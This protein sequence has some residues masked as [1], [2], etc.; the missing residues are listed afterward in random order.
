MRKLTMLLLPLLLLALSVAAR[1]GRLLADE[2]TYDLVP[3]DQAAAPGA[4]AVAADDCR[5]VTELRLIPTT[6]AGWHALLDQMVRGLCDL[7]VLPD[8]RLYRL[9][10]VA[11]GP[12]PAFSGTGAGG[13][14]LAIRFEPSG[15]A[16]VTEKRAGGETLH[17][18]AAGRLPPLVAVGAH[19][20]RPESADTAAAALCLE[21]DTS[22]GQPIAWLTAGQPSDCN[23]S[24][25]V[26]LYL[27][28]LV[29]DD[30]GLGYRGLWITA[31]GAYQV[32]IVVDAAGVP[33]RVSERPPAGEARVWAVAARFQ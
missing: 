1:S 8:P 7:N 30:N 33:L 27:L 17:M 14:T 29:Q 12:G 21:Q 15:R 13:Q 20:L 23:A 11:D 22:N 16:L 4:G 32:T 25:P 10:R 26:R 9:T 5:T 31:D 2:L 19:P 3:A 28:D 6:G 24:Q 18:A